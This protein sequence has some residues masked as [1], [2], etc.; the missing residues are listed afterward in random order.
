MCE[1]P[2]HPPFVSREDLKDGWPT[3]ILAF[4]LP[5]FRALDNQNPTHSWLAPMLVKGCFLQGPRDRSEQGA[6]ADPGQVS[7]ASL[8]QPWAKPSLASSFFLPSL[9]DNHSEL[10]A[11]GSTSFLSE[12]KQGIILQARRLAPLM[13]IIIICI[14]TRSFIMGILKY[15]TNNN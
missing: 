5:S 3:A 13:T 14:Y 12:L 7:M 2:I 11:W 10:S 9:W 8:P 6:H 4:C 1:V 15:I